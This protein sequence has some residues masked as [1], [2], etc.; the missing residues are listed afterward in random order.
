MNSKHF[1]CTV[2]DVLEKIMEIISY[3][4][5]FALNPLSK[6]KRKTIARIYGAEYRLASSTSHPP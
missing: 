5:R 4:F 2:I 6:L 3:V 1:P